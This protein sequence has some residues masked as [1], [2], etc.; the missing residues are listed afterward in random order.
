MA[1]GAFS[2]AM[3]FGAPLLGAL[4]DG[5]GRKKTLLL[6]LSGLAMSYVLLAYAL[7]FKSLWL[8]MAGRLIGGFFSGC[9][10]VAQAS[11]I[12]VTEEK[13][14]ARYIG[15]IMFFVSLGYVVGPL[16]GGYLSDPALV[17]WFNLQTP[18]IFVAALS[19]VNLL[20][21]LLVFQDQK[22]NA[23]KRAMT[24]P[25]P[26]AN[27]L[28]AVRIKDIRTYA[29][30]L[31]L[32][33]VGWNI[34]FQF[35]GLYL[36]GG[37][38]FAQQEVSNFISW[39]GFALALAFLFL[40]GPAMKVLKPLSMVGL[41]LVLMAFCIGVTL[42]NTNLYILYLLAVLGAVG[43]GM[44][45]SGLMS[46][47]SI[48]IDASKQGSI[49]GMAAAIAAFSAG[50]SGF[51]FGFVANISVNA[52]IECALFFVCM[53]ITICCKKHYGRYIQQGEL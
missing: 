42:L 31:L 13:Q 9:L 39:T 29:L 20:I 44:S 22:A 15:Y 33:L 4:S 30:L 50:F 49:M 41:A 47:L 23:K 12:D 2:I 25:N 6:C 52:P 3:F 43:F 7:A 48:C 35:I 16:I 19:V 46:Q 36:T 38:G 26:I 14:R 40:V 53:A 51:A 37:L 5:L 45:Y 27:L 18:F 21:L 24:L 32:M 1:L 28:D 17:P 34:F 11:I 10:P 8:F